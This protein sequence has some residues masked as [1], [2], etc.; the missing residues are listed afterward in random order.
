MPYLIESFERPKNVMQKSL[1]FFFCQLK[2]EFMFNIFLD[3]FCD[4]RNCCSSSSLLLS[5]VCCFEDAGLSIY[6]L[7]GF[8]FVSS[9]LFNFLYLCS[10]LQTEILI[11]AR[12][13][14]SP[15]EV[16]CLLVQIVRV[17]TISPN[18][19]FEVLKRL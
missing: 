14:I 11:S 17:K 13:N 12:A 8:Y 2:A 5:C 4:K 19:S 16:L 9:V 10:W 6:L 15:K 3:D 18:L 7:E 1:C